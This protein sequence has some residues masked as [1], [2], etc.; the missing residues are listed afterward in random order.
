M[1]EM[2]FAQFCLSTHL[3]SLGV[4]ILLLDS[5]KREEQMAMARKLFDSDRSIEVNSS[6]GNEAAVKKS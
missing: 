5:G 6:D 1:V 4:V 2:L 3:C